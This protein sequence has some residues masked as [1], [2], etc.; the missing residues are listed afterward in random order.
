MK[1][2][3]KTY[4][5]NTEEIYYEKAKDIRRTAEVRSKGKEG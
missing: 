2:G 4:Y 1:R 3:Q 5:E